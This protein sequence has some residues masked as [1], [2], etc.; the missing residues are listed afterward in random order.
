[1]DGWAAG[2]LANRNKEVSFPNPSG[3]FTP[4][5]TDLEMEVELS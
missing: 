4:Y 1:M 3:Y 5:R 2:E